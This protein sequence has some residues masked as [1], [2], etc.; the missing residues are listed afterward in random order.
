MIDFPQLTQDCHEPIN[1]VDPKRRRPVAHLEAWA[2]AL[3]QPP[4]DRALDLGLA[5]RC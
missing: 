5:L 2:T 3:R 4:C 1:S